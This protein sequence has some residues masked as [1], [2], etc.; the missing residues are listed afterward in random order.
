[1]IACLTA[2]PDWVGL[3]TQYIGFGM[4][5]GKLLSEFSPYPPPLPLVIDGG[6]SW[7]VLR[8]L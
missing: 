4:L 6:G 8:R 2:V 3:A 1:M 5:G 7:R